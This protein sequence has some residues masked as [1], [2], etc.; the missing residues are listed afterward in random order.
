MAGTPR[1]MV[2]NDDGYAMTGGVEKQ[3]EKEL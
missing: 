3:Y 2:A 1:Q